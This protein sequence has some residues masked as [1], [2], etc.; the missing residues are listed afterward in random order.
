MN[1]HRNPPMDLNF[2]ELNP[3]HIF[4]HFPKIHFSSIVMDLWTEIACTP[5]SN[6]RCRVHW[7]LEA[8]QLDW[9]Q[10]ETVW[11]VNTMLETPWL[12]KQLECPCTIFGMY[13]PPQTR[14]KAYLTADCQM[15][16]T[17]MD[18][19]V[20]CTLY[21][22]WTAWMADCWLMP[23]EQRTALWCRRKHVYPGNP[24]CNLWSKRH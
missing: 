2:S 17:V 7:L 8:L 18:C 13:K 5:R 19:E 22:N 12:G 1:G 20:L 4:T 24:D 6:A 16:P 3:A 15:E 10:W 9:K 14:V 21:A 23:G 11:Y